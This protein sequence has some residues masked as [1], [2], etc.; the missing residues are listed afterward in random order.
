M[1]GPFSQEFFLSS[2]P[3]AASCRT[4][5]YFGTNGSRL[6][7]LYTT[8]HRYKAPTEAFIMCNPIGAEYL[9]AF[10][11]LERISKALVDKGF[12]VL[13]FDYADTGQSFRGASAP[14][15]E[16]WLSNVTDAVD[17]LR[18]EH[19][20]ARISL[21]GVRFGAS[22]ALLASRQIR[23]NSVIALDP[24]LSPTVFISELERMQRVFA[25]AL[26]RDLDYPAWKDDGSFEDMGAIVP[27]PIVDGLLSTDW[28][29]Q[30]PCQC[31][32]LLLVSSPRL[33]PEHKRG[34]ESV[35]KSTPWGVRMPLDVE[36]VYR[37]SC[38]S[39][40]MVT[41]LCNRIVMLAS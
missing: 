22:I 10:P 17:L 25:L 8:P 15:I 4:P 32:Q 38:A 20:L 27:K 6:F 2:Q 5:F 40:V 18:L 39:P 37:L 19:N 41:E 3:P 1:N 29:P 35:L 9:I 21:F 13:R 23:V 33:H 24:V 14:D 16:T 7:G 28:L 26:G 30:L 11:A 12:G 31:R 36:P 34:I